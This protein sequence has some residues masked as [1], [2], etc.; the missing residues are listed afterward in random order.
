MP[1]ILAL[2]LSAAIYAIAMARLRALGRR[3]AERRPASPPWWLGYTFDAVN[4]LVVLLFFAGFA[5]AGLPGPLALLAGALLALFA[6]AIDHLALAGPARVASGVALALIA[7]ISARRIE[8]ALGGLV[9]A[10][11]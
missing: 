1:G 7:G 10:P 4:M 3:L 9:R 5:L 11:F 6:Y 2:A 8:H